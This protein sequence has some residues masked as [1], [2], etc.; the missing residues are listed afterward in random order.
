VTNANLEEMF[1][2][3]GAVRSAEVIM[4]RDKGT[5]KDFGFVEMAD[6]QA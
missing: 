2:E 4:D 1:A 6:D 3:H 5:S